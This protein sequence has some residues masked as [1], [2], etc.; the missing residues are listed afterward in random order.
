MRT[1]DSP[2]MVEL[3][4]RR[5]P[6]NYDAVGADAW[7]CET[8]MKSS[9]LFHAARTDNAF[10]ISMISVNPWTPTEFECHVVALCAEPHCGLE[11][12]PLLRNSVAFGKA[13]KCKRWNI[14]SETQFDLGPLAM[15]VGAR[16]KTPRYTLDL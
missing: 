12:L 16:L 9:L 4:R 13:R 3:G 7:F 2:W 8:V 5:Y 14:V 11:C 1:E 6:E 10:C 15:R